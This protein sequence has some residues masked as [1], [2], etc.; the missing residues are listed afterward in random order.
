MEVGRLKSVTEH[1]VTITACI[2]ALG[3][4]V[5]LWMLVRYLKKAPDKGATIRLLMAIATL[6]STLPLVLDALAKLS[7]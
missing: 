4:L 2:I 6:L 3:Y 1:A 5:T 7:G